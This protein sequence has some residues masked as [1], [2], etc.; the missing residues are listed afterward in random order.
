MSDNPS[1]ETTQCRKRA[2]FIV[3]DEGISSGF[4]DWAERQFRKLLEPAHVE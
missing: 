4:Q 1:T 2:D 3:D